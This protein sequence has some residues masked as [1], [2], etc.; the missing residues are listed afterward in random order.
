MLLLSTC[1]GWKKTHLPITS[2]TRGRQ[3]P[4]VFYPDFN[5]PLHPQSRVRKEDNNKE[6][7]RT[8]NRH[9]KGKR[10]WVGLAC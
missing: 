9:V 7:L 4:V 8:L 3:V 1:T 5:N 10:Q 2:S 6:K